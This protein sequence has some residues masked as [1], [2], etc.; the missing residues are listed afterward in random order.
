MRI[1][2]PVRP[3]DELTLRQICVEKRNS[4]SRPGLGVVKS[5]IALSNAAGDEVMVMVSNFL[6][7]VRA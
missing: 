4:K 6:V 7:E 5:R 3:G 1:P 2:V